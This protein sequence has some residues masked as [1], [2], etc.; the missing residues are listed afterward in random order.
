MNARN[1][2]S[3]SFT[4]FVRAKV[5]LGC[6]SWIVAVYLGMAKRKHSCVS[7]MKLSGPHFGRGLK[8]R[9][10]TSQMSVYAPQMA[11]TVHAMA[12]AMMESALNSWSWMTM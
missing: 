8:S 12:M 10:V 9:S 11:Q 5:L 3:R 2:T 7:F 1:S 4:S 6:S